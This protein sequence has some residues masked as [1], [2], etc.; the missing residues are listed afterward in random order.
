[1][2]PAS[3]QPGDERAGAAPV[4]HRYSQT[5]RLWQHVIG[6]PHYRLLYAEYIVKHRIGNINTRRSYAVAKLHRG[7]DFI[8]QQ[9]TFR[10]FQYI[11]CQNATTYRLS[12]ANAYTIKFRGDRAVTGNCSAGGICHPVCAAAIDGADG[13]LPNDE[14]TYITLWLCNMLLHI[15]DVVLVRAYRLLV[16]EYCLR[17]IVIINPCQQTTP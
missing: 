15:V 17:C 1:M 12:R 3:T 13:S 10:I 9:T 2:Q 5:H 16:F 14:R 6:S 8:D 7:I 11:D 4:L